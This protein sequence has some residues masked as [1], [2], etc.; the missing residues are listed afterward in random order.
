M[1]H[2]EVRQQTA[3]LFVALEYGEQLAHDCA[4]QQVHSIIDEMSDVFYSLDEDP[5]KY[6]ADL[7]DNLPDWIHGSCT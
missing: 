5:G 7:L 1:M 3:R 4:R 2:P 6:R